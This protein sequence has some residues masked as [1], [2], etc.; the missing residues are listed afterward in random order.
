MFKQRLTAVLHAAHNLY[1]I[2]A[3]YLSVY[4]QLT[5][6]LQPRNEY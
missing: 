5:I 6:K 3:H 1:N 2:P 4:N